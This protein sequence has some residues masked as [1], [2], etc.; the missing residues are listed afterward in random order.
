MRGEER[1]GRENG[2]KRRGEERDGKVRRDG[3]E[4]GEMRKGEERDGMKREIERKVERGE[5]KRQE[6]KK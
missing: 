3:K 4:N 1:D 5:G 2:E 6:G